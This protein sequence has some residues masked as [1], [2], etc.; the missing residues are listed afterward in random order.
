MTLIKKITIILGLAL[1]QLSYGQEKD[2]IKIYHSI[3]EALAEPE[4]VEIL[5]LNDVKDLDSLKYLSQFPKLTSL[6]LVD[7]HF[8]AAPESISNLKSLK[9]LK[10]IKDDFY[11]IPASYSKLEN[12]EKVE[13]IYD[14]HLSIE[15]AFNFVNGLPKLIELRIEGLPGAS[16]SEDLMFPS[17]LRIL[18]LRNNHLNLLPKGIIKLQNLEVLDLGNNEFF[19]I[20]NYMGGLSQLN[21]LYLDQQPFLQFDLAFLSINK[22]PALRNLHLEGNHLKNQE[23]SELSKNQLYHVFLDEQSLMLKSTYTPHINLYLPPMP[24]HSDEIEKSSYKIKLRNN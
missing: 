22:L 9:E 1:S 5:E 21:T 3:S 19:E 13:F 2:S 20:P 7:F 17:S 23:V 6:S 16:F 18:S 4:K 10:F 12:L 15:S 24:K 14:T 11:T 8:G